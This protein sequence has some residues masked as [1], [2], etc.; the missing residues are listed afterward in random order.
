MVPTPLK[1]TDLLLAWNKGEQ[2]AFT[3]LV[4]LVY[5]ELRRIARRCLR[6]ERRCHT[7][8]PTALVHEAYARLIDKNR[9]QWQHRAH[10]FAVAAQTMR[11]ILVDYA[12]RRHAARRGGTGLT[13]LLEE[14]V[15]AGDR[16]D[17]DLIWLDDAL[18]GLAA[19]DAKQSQIVELR[20]FAGLTIEE[21]A[22]VLAISVATVKREWSL[23]RAWLYREMS[24]P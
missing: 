14:T 16:R 17:V 11:R 18:N 3:K 19:V 23:A 2:A 21:T 8:S 7:L 13:L 15:G 22:E 1:V 5:D 12:R 6:Q 10:F 20:Y 24:Q 9:V 4:P